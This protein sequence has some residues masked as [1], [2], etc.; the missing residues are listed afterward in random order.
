M[1]RDDLEA[2]GNMLIFFLKNGYDPSDTIEMPNWMAYN[3]PLPVP[4]TPADTEARLK[5]ENKYYKKLENL[6]VNTTLETLCEGLPKAFL[7]YMK[8]CRSLEFD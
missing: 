4:T 3:I 6:K 7:D 1:R 8:H 5:E 2:V